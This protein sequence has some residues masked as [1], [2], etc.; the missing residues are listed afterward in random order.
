[1]KAS[2]WS[3]STVAGG[4]RVELLDRAAARRD[5]PADPQ[6]GEPFAV[7]T[8]EVEVAVEGSRPVVG[9][10]GDLDDGLPAGGDRTPREGGNRAAAGR[11]DVEQDDGALPAVDAAETAADLAA[12]LLDGAEVVLGGL[13]NELCR[14]GLAEEKGEQEQEGSHQR[15]G[16]GSDHRCKGTFFLIFFR[17]YFARNKFCRIFALAKRVKPSCLNSSV[18]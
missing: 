1:M 10:V 3:S 15:P 2:L 17:N 6:H 4:D 13:E 7:G 14:E 12:R 5:R 8:V 11:H 16:F 18:G 9:V